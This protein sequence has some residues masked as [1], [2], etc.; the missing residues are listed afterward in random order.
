MAGEAS[1]T[2]NE[3][4]GPSLGLI[5]IIGKAMNDQKIL[6]ALFPSNKNKEGLYEAAKK[7]ACIELS[8]CDLEALVKVRTGNLTILD[9]IKIAKECVGNQDPPPPPKWCC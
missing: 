1:S 2:K 6:D 4:H 9:L 3:E 7:N 8:D 5:A